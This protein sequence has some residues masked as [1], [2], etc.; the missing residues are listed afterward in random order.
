MMNKT[1]S[2]IDQ[3]PK[4]EAIREYTTRIESFASISPGLVIE[5]CK[6]IIESILK[7]ILV[8]VYSKTEADLK[9][10]EIGKLFKEVKT[11]LHLEDKGYTNII[12]SFTKAICEFRN[13]LGETSHGKD[14]Y[15]LE[16]SRNALFED[17]LNFLLS[18]TD[19]ISYFIL[20]YY[21]N[22]YPGFKAKKEELKYANNEE[23]NEWFDSKEPIVTVSGIELLPSEVLFNGDLAAY[24]INLDEYKAK[25]ELIESLR[26][27]PNFASTHK[28]IEKLNQYNNFSNLQIERLN[29]AYRFNNQVNWISD[30]FDVKEFFENINSENQM[31]ESVEAMTV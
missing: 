23:F 24:K 2:F 12:G 28:I 13:K 11:T 25:D 16:S 17:E 31:S 15:T 27:S 26:I 7:T 5:N 18:T 14:I 10:D 4:W 6:S 3:N 8:E 29:Q 20:S 9:N 19:N 30:D 1:V 22:L 21:Q